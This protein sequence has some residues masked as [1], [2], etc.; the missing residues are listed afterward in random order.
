MKVCQK[1]KDRHQGCHA[2]CEDYKEYRE[3]I[4][5]DNA[6]KR[7]ENMVDGYT[8]EGNSKR[9]NRFRRS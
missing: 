4:E 1:C 3:K 2:E 7:D 6:R 9:K 5:E 8:I